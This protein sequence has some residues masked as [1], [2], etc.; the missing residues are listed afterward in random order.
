MARRKE[1]EEAG[2]LVKARFRCDARPDAKSVF[3]A[4]DFNGWGPSADRMRKRNGSFSRQVALTPGEHQYKFVVDG[5]WVT[6]TGVEAQVPN[7]AGSTNS[8]IR[9]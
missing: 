4:G 3:L 1:N 7:G 2:R 5:E 6:D 9:V 8:V